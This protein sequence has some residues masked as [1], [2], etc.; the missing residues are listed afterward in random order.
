[1]RR[2]RTLTCV[3]C[4]AL[5]SAACHRQDQQLQQHTEKLASLRATTV[6]VGEAWLGGD[7][8]GT[9][10]HTALDQTYMLVE[11]ER[12]ALAAA[13]QALLDPRGAAL[14]QAAERHSR[15]L[16]LMIHDVQGADAEATRRHLADLSAM[17]SDTR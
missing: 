16:A 6:A 3:L 1:M 12:T 10:A 15:V 11:Q 8:S 17:A 4:W 7:V 5:S 14:S 2:H 9:Y 13:P